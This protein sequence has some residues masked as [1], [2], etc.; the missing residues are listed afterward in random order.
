MALFLE[1]L[2]ADAERHG[3]EQRRPDVDRSGAEATLEPGDAGPAI[4]LGLSMVRGIGQA[5]EAPAVASR[6]VRRRSVARC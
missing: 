2:K 3:V 4:R 5:A 1:E 6:V